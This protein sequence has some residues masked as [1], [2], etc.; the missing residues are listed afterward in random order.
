MFIHLRL[1]N[2]LILINLTNEGF[3]RNREFNTKIPDLKTERFL[4][5]V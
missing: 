4:A 2:R 1:I 5:Q 3:V